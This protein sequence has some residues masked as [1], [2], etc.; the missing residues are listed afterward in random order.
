MKL[1]AVIGMFF[2]CFSCSQPNEPITDFTPSF[3]ESKKTTHKIKEG[4]EFTFGYLEVPE[5]RQNPNSNT[6]KLPIYIFKSRSKNPKQDPVIYTGGGPG[7]TS[8]R[9]SQ[10]MKYYK[11]L[12]D[13]DF[14][15][16]EQRGNQFAQPNLACPEWAEAVYQSNLP[17]FRDRDTDRIFNEAV[18]KCRERLV[19]RG[20]DLNGYHTKESAADIEDLRRVLNIEQ[21][22]FLSGSY[23][24]K[25]AQVL[26]REYPESI[27][28]VVMDSPLPLESNY[29]EVSVTNLYE[30][31]NKLL[32]DCEKDSDCNRTFP[33]LKNRFLQFL[34]A[35]YQSPL[36]ITIPHPIDSTDQ[37][38]KLK[39]KD[40]IAVFTDASTSEVPSFPL[41]INKL[42]NGDYTSIKK[43]LT[44]LLQEPGN[45]DGQGMRLSVWCA[46]EFPF[47]NQAIVENQKNK[48]PE[49]VG[50]SPAVFTS[51]V[52]N[53][54]GVQK[55]DDLENEPVKSNVPVLLISGEYDENT[56]PYFGEMLSDN[57]SN[58]FHM[59]FKG[60]KHSPTT[61]W[62]NPCAMQAANDFFNNPK[63]SPNPDCFQKIKG[64]EFKT[65]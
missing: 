16:F 2:F 29:D 32:E 60:W 27:R 41:E 12:D 39:G 57:F 37:V 3:K 21:Y 44:N 17:E 35:T 50:L 24:T 56:P 15:L 36:S 49:L 30:A 26:L 42:L 14:I 55:V 7:Y 64:P 13:R 58:S 47:V 43:H 54:W 51:E 28:S 6:I 65:E 8:M 34:E 61:N 46:E 22:N 9:A 59:V 52:C 10:Y 23:S 25:I 48:Y 20:I 18:L 38:F 5:N 45:G 53:I 62:S 19:E 63:R 1:F 33:N 40:L 31:T 4:Q 11:Y